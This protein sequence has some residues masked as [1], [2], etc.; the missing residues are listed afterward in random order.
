MAGYTTLPSLP[1]LHALGTPRT[2]RPSRMPLVEYMLQLVR[3]VPGG[4]LGSIFRVC[5]GWRPLCHPFLPKS[6]KIR[7]GDLL[8]LP[9]SCSGQNG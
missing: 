7:Q 5:P 1:P 9:G 4:A 2:H 3:G 6:V 8:Q